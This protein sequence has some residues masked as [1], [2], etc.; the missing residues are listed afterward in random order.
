MLNKENTKTSEQI[1]EE[2]KPLFFRAYEL[3]AIYDKTRNRLQKARQVKNAYFYT[4]RP[5]CAEAGLDFDKIT[6]LKH[7]PA[8]VGEW[9]RLYNES[10]EKESRAEMA[11]EV[12]SINFKNY[13]DYFAALIADYI[14]PYWREFIQRGGL[15]TLAEII[16]KAAPGVKDYTAGAVSV[17]VFLDRA[18]FDPKNPTKP[19]SWARVV[20]DVLPGWACGVYGHCGKYY[21]NN[22]GEVWHC[23]EVPALVDIAKYKSA[24]EKIKDY[25][26]KAETIRA[27]CLSFAKSAGLL[28]HVAIIGTITETK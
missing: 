22:P 13:I 9:S 3:G 16:N 17:S 6:E 12:A 14:R 24:I 10:I 4:T 19:G 28:G 2:L 26:K 27:E 21:Q 25:F 23:A 15:S 18:D 1:A 20:V 11:H 8:T 7:N 5:D